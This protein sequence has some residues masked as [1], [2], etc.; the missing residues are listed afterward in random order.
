MRTQ[1]V[2][3]LTYLFG[4]PNDDQAV[5]SNVENTKICA[6]VFRLLGAPQGPHA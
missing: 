4:L 1:N 6:N 2:M 3:S 5:N